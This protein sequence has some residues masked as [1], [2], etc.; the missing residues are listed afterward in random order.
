[1]S[2]ASSSYPLLRPVENFIG[3]PGKLLIDGQWVPSTGGRTFETFN[4]ATGEVLAHVAE[5]CV[6]EI[7][8]VVKAADGNLK[9]VT[10]RRRCVLAQ[11]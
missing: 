9:K 2:V 10:R 8:H 6:L 3:T 5:G 4:P 11:A 1:M 7:D